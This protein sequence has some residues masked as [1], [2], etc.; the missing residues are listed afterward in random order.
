MQADIYCFNIISFEQI[1]KVR[2]DVGDI[3]PLRDTI[4]LSF[5]D[6]GNGHNISAINTLVVIQVVLANLAHTDDPDPNGS[7]CVTHS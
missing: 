5:I 3:I 2:I 6:V 7:I 1:A 4:G